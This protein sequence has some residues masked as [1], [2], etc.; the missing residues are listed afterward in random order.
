M[1]ENI[2]CFFPSIKIKKITSFSLFIYISYLLL[3]MLPIIINIQEAI[4][5]KSIESRI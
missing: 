3:C 1:R 4:K 2:I 5:W